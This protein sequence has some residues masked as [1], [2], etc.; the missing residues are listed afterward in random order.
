MVKTQLPRK[1]RERLRHKQEVLDKALKLF[2][3]S[4][5]HNVSMQQIAESSEFAVGTLYNFF[6]SK[7]T[8]FKEL[9]GNCRQRIQGTLMELLDTPGTEKQRLTTFIRHMPELLE[10]NAELIRLY[11]SEVGTRAAKLSKEEDHENFH[12]LLNTRLEEILAAGMSKGVFRKVD[13]A[14]TAKS[15]NSVLE[16]LA[17]EMAGRFDRAQA[18]AVFDK[19]EQLFVGGLLLPEEQGNE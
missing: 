2:S 16:T 3:Q 19:V 10:K 12:A 14:I 4:G 6:D 13:A 7:E 1:E 15:I 5:F 17:F 8:L 18:Q 9:I 11:V